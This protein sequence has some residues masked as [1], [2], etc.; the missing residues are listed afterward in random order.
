MPADFYFANSCCK[1]YR[2]SSLMSVS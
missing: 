1:L 2:I